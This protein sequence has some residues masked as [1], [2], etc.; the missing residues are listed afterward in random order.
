MDGGEAGRGLD[1]SLTPASPE[2][3]RQSPPGTPTKAVRYLH[4]PEKSRTSPPPI[5]LPHPAPGV[6]SS[7]PSEQTRKDGPGSRHT[8]FTTSA[9]S[10]P[11]T[12][13]TQYQSN[14]P[15]LTSSSASALAPT[16]ATAIDP[17]VGSLHPPYRPPEKVDDPESE[18]PPDYSQ[19]V[20]HAEYVDPDVDMVDPMLPTVTTTEV[21]DYDIISG[22]AE[23]EHIELM[24]D[25]PSGSRRHPSGLDGWAA[26]VGPG[27]PSRGDG[28]WGWGDEGQHTGSRWSGGASSSPVE[29]PQLGRGHMAR[30][31]L[32]QI[33]PHEL[34][35][36]VV[37]TLPRTRTKAGPSR[38]GSVS[39]L[40]SPEPNTPDTTA[41]SPTITM[42]QIIAALP[43]GAE[44][45]QNWYFSPQQ[46][47]WMRVEV[48]DEDEASLEAIVKG[49][50]AKGTVKSMLGPARRPLDAPFETFDH[51]H[52]LP[53]LP[54]DLDTSNTTRIDRVQLSDSSLEA[55][56]HLIPGLED[57]DVTQRCEAAFD[58]PQQEGRKLWYS[59]TR[60]KW[61]LADSQLVPGQIHR[62]LVQAFSEDRSRATGGV[63]DG[64]DPL[65][66][67]WDLLEVLLANPLFHGQ[68]GWVKLDNKRFARLIGTT[69]LASR[70]LQ[71]IG[72]SCRQEEDVLRVGPIGRKEGVTQEQVEQMDQYM[73]RAWIEISL[74]RAAY[75]NKPKGKL[76]YGS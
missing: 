73:L 30:S 70:I 5:D 49:D 40:K 14:N 44:D 63:E 24:Q 13:S 25:S 10:L 48:L 6:D 27:S 29:R 15:F 61:I 51:F 65:F 17:A 23:E 43:G 47:G 8:V 35:R 33:H 38:A 9:P 54:L 39:G 1:R 37:R 71:A 41:S 52:S 60:S 11:A 31:M 53:V 46:W 64:K 12:S 2:I 72:F 58:E 20:L 3:E 67:A 22:G 42:D 74:W 36:P 68:R 26:Q 32:R 76:C 34:V 50:D 4:S 57:E 55:W 62:G 7:V 21:H 45:Y 19:A 16:E 66:E 56:L 69:T 75:W 18:H 28:A 59:S